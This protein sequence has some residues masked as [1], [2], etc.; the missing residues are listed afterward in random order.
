[1]ALGEEVAFVQLEPGPRRAVEERRVEGAGTP[2]GADDPST[3]FPFISKMPCEQRL[4]LALPHA[5]ADDGQAVGNHPARALERARA[6]V[7]EA[8][9]A[10]EPGKLVQIAQSS[11]A[12]DTRITS[13][14]FFTSAR[15]HA[16]NSS[17]ELATTSAPWAVRLSRTCGLLRMRATSLC[18]RPTI[19][20]GV[21][22]GASRP[23]QPTAS[24]PFSPDSSRVG[25]SGRIA[26]RARLVTAS[27]LMRPER[28]CGSSGGTLSNMIGIC[29]AIRS[30]IAGAPPL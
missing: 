14:H 27:A 17:G 21:P 24:K 12:P 10:C 8:R 13:A 23:F 25:T 26:S 18:R 20:R 5:G 15:I 22:A 29:P 30:A 3:V 28:T 6:Q 16:A 19:S 11:L 7:A 2:P 9:A 4:H 1:M